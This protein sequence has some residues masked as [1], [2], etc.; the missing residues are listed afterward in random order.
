MSP[1]ILRLLEKGDRREGGLSSVHADT[2]R[3]ALEGGANEWLGQEVAFSDFFVPY[4]CQLSDLFYIIL[5]IKVSVLCS[6]L[7][8]GLWHSAPLT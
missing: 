5:L 6:L 8:L 4:F 2:V 3:K 1:I 7:S